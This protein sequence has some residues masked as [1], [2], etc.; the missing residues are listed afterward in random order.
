M[1]T[2]SRH[3]AFPLA[4]VTTGKHLLLVG[5]G[6]LGESRLATA[7]LFD[8]ERITFIATDPTPETHDLAAMDER[9]LL[10]ERAVTEADVDASDIVIESTLDKALGQQLAGWCRPR[11]I[12]L[13][14]MD[15]LES[16]D[17]YY[18]ALIMRGPLI[19][20][21]ISGGETPALSATLRRLL[22]QRLGPG[23]CNAALLMAETRRALPQ[24][25]ARM[26]LLKGIAHDER[27]PALIA[28]NDIRGM[29]KL[30]EDAIG[31]MPN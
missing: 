16:C 23:W 15:K 7:L 1:S 12:P 25:V 21:I 31:R 11:R 22:E 2:S 5:G 29:R 30:I 4:F 3:K 10:R 8:W 20:A 28:E 17:V 14:A 6:P 19:L 13:N 27:L 24:N 9:V 26:E 18:P